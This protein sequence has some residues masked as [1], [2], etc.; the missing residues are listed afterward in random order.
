M[1]YRKVVSHMWRDPRVRAL[2]RTS[3]LLWAYFCN[4]EHSNSAGLFY[5][6]AGYAEADLQYD[7]SEFRDSIAEIVT[8][9][10]AMYDEKNSLLLLKKFFKYNPIANQKHLKGTIQQLGSL[11]RT[12]LLPFLRQCLEDPENHG[13]S[14]YN[15]QFLEHLREITP[16]PP[17]NGEAPPPAPTAPGLPIPPKPP[18]KAKTAPDKAEHFEFVNAWNTECGDPLGKVIQV[19][20]NRKIHIGAR[21]KERPLGEWIGIFRRIAAS[22]FLTGNNDKNWKADF[23]WVTK[24]TDVAVKV[25]EGKYDDHGNRL[26]PPPVRGREAIKSLAEEWGVV[27]GSGN[28]REGDHDDPGVLQ[29]EPGHDR[30]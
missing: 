3:K 27:D 18:K 8:S 14:V 2:S 6:P 21:L 30:S 13:A 25:L 12:H 4:N 22:G 23:D 1:G 5:M 26:N 11:P 7:V 17:E 16:L 10:L 24:G 15:F 19:T 9:G 28:L 29:S 20:E